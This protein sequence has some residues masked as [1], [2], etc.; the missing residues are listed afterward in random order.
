MPKVYGD[1]FSAKIVVVSWGSLKG[2]MLDVLEKLSSVAFVHFSFVYPLD[3]E[4]IKKFL[5]PWANK[6]VLIENNSFG[7]F[8]NIIEGL[9][10]E[11][12]EKILKYDGRLFYPE[13]I[14]ESLNSLL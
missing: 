8:G 4:K 3:K 13:E 1:P 9:G 10:F 11:F 14:V 5:K 12:K 7:Q 2:S 6:L